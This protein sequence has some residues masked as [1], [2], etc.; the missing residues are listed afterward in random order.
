MDK[1]FTPITILMIEDNPAQ[2]GIKSKDL[3]SRGID[4]GDLDDNIDVP[5][6]NLKKEENKKLHNLFTLKVLQHPEEIK[7][8][9]SNCLE[10]EDKEGFVALGSIAGVVPEIVEFDYKLSDN[11]QINREKGKKDEVL[12]HIKY[13]SLF[14]KLREHYNPNFL[15]KSERHLEKKGNEN[16]TEKDFIER[17]NKKENATGS[18]T[19]YKKDEQELENDELGLYAG[20]EI[21]RIFRNHICIGIPATSNFDVRE[22]LHAFGKFYEWINDYD[23]GTMFSRE[24][25]GNKDW[26]SVIAAAVK[27]LRIRIETQLQSNKIIL[28]LTQLLAWANENPTEQEKQIIK[29]RIFTFQSAY[30]KRHLPLDGLFIDDPIDKRDE[31]IKEWINGKDDKLGL[32]GI[33]TSSLPVLKDTIKSYESIYGTYKT[34]FLN[35]ILLSDFSKREKEN[36]LGSYANHYKEL[37]STFGVT[38]NGEIGDDNLCSVEQVFADKKGK[39]KENWSEDD[40]SK[41]RLLVLFICTRLWIDHQGGAKGHADNIPLIKED[42]FHVLHPIFNSPLSN[43]KK[44]KD[45]NPLLLLMHNPL[46]NESTYTGTFDNWIN[47]KDTRIPQAEWHKFEWISDGEKKI[48]KSQFQ[49]ELFEIKKQPDWLL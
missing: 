45:N 44:A 10:K 37:K 26:D 43:S 34:K 38:T 41:L 21:T 7:E 46:D 22:R 36:N 29:E 20:V 13:W 11:V 16:Y 48:V 14:K 18:E 40:K 8:F 2:E 39:K 27:Q 24:E 9:I 33:I 3:K 30:G 19:W 15:F 42:Y 32:L 25:R 6:I 17:I 28:N 12:S 35:R 4:I 31:A 23:L 5:G 49:S 47:V 1:T